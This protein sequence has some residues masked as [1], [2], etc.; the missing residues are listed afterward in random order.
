MKIARYKGPPRDLIHWIAHIAT[1]IVLFSRYSHA[2]LVI[3]G[4]CYSSSIRDGGV[5]SKGI[6]LQSGHWDVVDI[7]GTA[8]DEA[9]ALAW[10]AEHDGESYDW[11]GALRFL[12]PFIPQS[13]GRWYCFESIAAALGLQ[14]P[15]RWSLRRLVKHFTHHRD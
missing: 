14:R 6:D 7:G 12:L 3:D 13:R 5:R 11:R 8:L 9:R 2:E 4:R 15:H 10:F 1:C